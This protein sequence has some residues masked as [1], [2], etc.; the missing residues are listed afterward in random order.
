MTEPEQTRLRAYLLSGGNMLVAI[1]AETRDAAPALTKVLE[2]F[3][4][5]PTDLLVIEADPTLALPNTRGDTFVALAKPS[6]ITTGLVSSSEMRD[7][8]KIVLDV[9]RPLERVPTAATLTDLV[10]SSDHSFAINQER[11]SDIAH[12]ASL[13]IPDRRGTDRSGPFVLAMAAEGPKATRDAPHGP[14]VV[15]FGSSYAFATST[16]RAPLPWHGTAFLVGNAIAW[17]AAKPFVLDVPDKPS[18]GAGLRMNAEIE[19]EVRRYVVVYMPLAGITFGVL[20]AVRRRS[21][22]NKKPPRRPVS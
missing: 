8:P 14:R 19:G 18:V 16:F 21:T 9:V 2:P 17:L 20:V 12:S 6:V 1:G 11:A 5:R 7:V 3:G 10:G 4:I 22:E 13:E 15:V